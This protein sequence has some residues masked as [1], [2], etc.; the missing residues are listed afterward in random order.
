MRTN[1]A[2]QR[3]SDVDTIPHDPVGEAV[4]DALSDVLAGAT[5]EL[6]YAPD[7]APAPVPTPEPGMAMAT[8]PGPPGWQTPA[9]STPITP[10]PWPS[11]SPA[12]PWPAWP[13]PPASATTS[14]ATPC[15]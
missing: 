5:V 12:C 15:P 14:K 11:S 9:S 8:G 1:E 4:A 2:W 6:S 13:P 3:T 7:S 10:P